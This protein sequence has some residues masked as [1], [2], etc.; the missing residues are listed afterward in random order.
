MMFL[1]GICIPA[2]DGADFLANFGMVCQEQLHGQNDRSAGI[3]V[4]VQQNLGIVRI[5]EGPLS[6]LGIFDEQAG[7]IRQVLAIDR[8]AISPTH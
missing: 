5:Q 2:D 4:M 8:Q 3:Q 1:P 7:S 6:S